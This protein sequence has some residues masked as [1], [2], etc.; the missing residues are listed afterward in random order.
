VTNLTSKL[1]AV[2]LALLGGALTTTTAQNSL[3]DT[4]WRLESFSSGGS[5]TPVLSSNPI[6]LKFGSDGSASGSTGCN[7]YRGEYHVSGATIS[8]SRLISTRRACLD[9]NANRQETRYLA[10]LESA[11]RF[12]LADERLVIV[13]GNGPNRVN[14]ISE[15]GSTQSGERYEDLTTPATLLESFYNAVNSRDLDRA[16][17][18]WENPPQRFEEF[19]RGYSDTESVRLLVEPPTRLEGAAGS[20][21][22]DVPTILVSRRRNGNER[23]FAGCY[24]TRRSNLG[25]NTGWRIYRATFAPAPATA[26]LSDLLARTCRA[27]K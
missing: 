23:I 3:A 10:A 2:I 25:S 26:T 20:T 21:Y 19:K 9:Q 7:N 8:F 27:N 24:V 5:N 6:T 15:S 12:T 22:A 18:Y 11:R 4:A 13:Y 14:F 17:R 1:F 16:Y